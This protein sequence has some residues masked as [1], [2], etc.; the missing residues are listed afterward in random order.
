MKP[1]IQPGTIEQRMKHGFSD[2]FQAEAL[3]VDKEIDANL[4]EA[5]RVSCERIT[6]YYTTPLANRIDKY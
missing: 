6:D 3:P 2:Y 4:L 5:C 1:F